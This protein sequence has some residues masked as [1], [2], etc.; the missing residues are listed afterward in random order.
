MKATGQLVLRVG[1]ALVLAMVAMTAMVVAP[2]LAAGDA[3]EAFCGNEGLEGF[4]AA[5]P[6]CRAYER[7]TPTF[8]NGFGDAGILALSP[9]SEELIA[10]T[11]PGF[12]GTE[13]NY[14]G[15]TYKMSRTSNGWQTASLSP[16]ASLYPANLFYSASEDLSKSVWALRSPNESILAQNL[17]LREADGTFVKIGSMVPPS[18]EA[19]PRA[20]GI[21]FFLG[22]NAFAGAS[23]DLSH[24]DFSIFNGAGGGTVWPG[25]TTTIFGTGTGS[26]S[27][28]YE[29]VGTGNTRPSLVGVET[30]GHLISDCG[31][32]FGSYES[33]DVYNAISTG[34]DKVYFTAEGRDRPGCTSAITSPEVTE[35][36]ARLN[37]SET[38]P[39]SEP[40]RVDCPGCQ[41]TERQPAEFQGASKD[42]SKSLFTT[43][44]ELL[45]G[46]TTENLYQYNFNAARGE[47]LERLSVG[48]SAPEVLGVSRLSEDGSHVYF[49]ARGR[50]T[51]AARGGGCIAEET[52]SEQEIEEE[53]HE[54]RCR[55]KQGAPNLY[56]YERDSEHPV[57]HIGFVA[58]LSEADTSV[59]NPKDNRPVQ[60]TPT[61]GRLVFVSGGALTKE[62][63]GE[64][65]QVYEFD[66]A[67]E[68]LSRISRGQS[69]YPQGTVN[70]D[71]SFSFIGAQQYESFMRPTSSNTFLSISNDGTEAMF[72]S[73]AA[74]TPSAEVAAEHG[75]ISV[76]EYR[77]G[78]R[79]ADGDV[80]LLSGGDDEGSANPQGLSPAGSD[81]FLSVT[82]S[83]VGEQT[84]PQLNIFDARIG[85]GFA[86]VQPPVGCVGEACLEGDGQLTPG[87]SPPRSAT[88]TP[89]G[90][91]APGADGQKTTAVV[92]PKS[93]PPSRGSA[94]RQT[95]LQRALSQCRRVRQHGARAKCE[96]RARDRFRRTR[97]SSKATGG[98][99]Q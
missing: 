81:A 52:L 33:H 77:S 87:L 91:T 83:L 66:A 79:V 89:D 24:V 97:H 54:G 8:Q 30:Q 56:L 35:V 7:V 27:S 37:G 90:A 17:Y 47:R 84:A 11:T 96:R 2:A 95:P 40:T 86:P 62:V 68:E 92:A 16:P 28:L 34:G 3:N 88:T 46:A 65:P 50:L 93:K 6:D 60:A 76:Y 74:L 58:T 49:V 73:P 21:Q 14:S 25:D 44:Q 12:A 78:S 71:N 55:A 64:A 20:N 10:T 63:S 26:G 5:L 13:S 67:T 9:G 59:W 94:R 99:G 75:V 85:G 15:P 1:C 32:F 43:T 80:Y 48:A 57:G 82:D 45:P 69:G 36:Y 18:S 61:G 98:K 29:Y 51:E 41:T 31:T 72:L 39:I 4:T 22:S 19:G 38:V 53:T 70:A 23:K 42:G